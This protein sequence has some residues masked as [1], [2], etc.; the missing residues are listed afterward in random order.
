M[1]KRQVTTCKN[2]D[3]LASALFVMFQKNFSQLPVIDESKSIIDILTANTIV[4]WLAQKIEDDIFSLEETKIIEVLNFQEYK[5]NY[6][7]INRKT[8]LFEIIELFS[9][10]LRKGYF[11]AAIITQNGKSSEKI[12]GIITQADLSSVYQK[13]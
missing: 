2:S 5:E 6:Q 9:S 7:I 11:D 3:N 12:L 8:T 13:L 4:R 10:R 1:F